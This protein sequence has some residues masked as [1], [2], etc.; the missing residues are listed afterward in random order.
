MHPENKT[1]VA[2]QYEYDG[3]SPLKEAQK[4]GFRRAFRWRPDKQ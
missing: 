2:V 4:L 1:A 3:P